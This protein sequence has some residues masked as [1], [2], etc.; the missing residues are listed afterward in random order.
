MNP[1]PSPV[2]DPQQAPGAAGLDNLRPFD[3]QKGPMTTQ[4]LQDIIG[5]EPHHWRGD[6]DGIE[7]FNGAFESLLGDDGPPAT[8]TAPGAETRRFY[9]IVRFQ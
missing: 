7:A 4:T 2:F 6:R 3:P 9:R 5:K 1:N 8:D